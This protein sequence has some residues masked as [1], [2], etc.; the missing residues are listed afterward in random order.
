MTY[1]E[2]KLDQRIEV[3]A[4]FENWLSMYTDKVISQVAVRA[5]EILN[6]EFSMKLIR[7]LKVREDREKEVR[8]RKFKYILNGESD[9]IGVHVHPL[10]HSGSYRDV[11]YD[12]YI[13]STEP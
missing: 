12:M 7:E 13:R 2:M 3:A 1:A 4:L 11:L 9:A 6:D 10:T 8:I 5:E